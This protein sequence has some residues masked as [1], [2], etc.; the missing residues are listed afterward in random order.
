MWKKNEDPGPSARHR[1]L[2]CYLAKCGMALIKEN[3]PV[4]K[5]SLVQR[6]ISVFILAFAKNEHGDVAAGMTTT[7]RLPS[8]NDST[9][10]TFRPLQ[11]RPAECTLLSIGQI[12]PN[13]ATCIRQAKA[14]KK[15]LQDK[16]STPL[17]ENAQFQRQVWRYRSMHEA[18]CLHPESVTNFTVRKSM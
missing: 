9:P 15:V 16:S 7:M 2:H 14:K 13:R 10:G 12:A 8:A 5:V 17:F 1:N 18:G 11:R 4:S 6:P 3:C